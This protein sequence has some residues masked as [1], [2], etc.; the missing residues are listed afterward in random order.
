MIGSVFNAGKIYTEPFMDTIVEFAPKA[1]FIK[2][3]VPPV[4]GSILLAAEV[5]G[6]KLT[7]I[8]NTLVGSAIDSF[9]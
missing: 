2:L 6:I 5:I 1:E 3:T 7:D 4:V 8:K 9:S